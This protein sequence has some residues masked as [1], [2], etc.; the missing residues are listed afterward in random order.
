MLES[1]GEIWREQWKAEGLLAGLAKGRAEGLEKGRAEGLEEG[2]AEGLEEGRARALLRLLERRFG[3][4]PEDQR[5]RV[6]TAGSDTLD[7]WLD[8]V[9][10]A[11]TPD[12]VFERR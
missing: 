8:R 2:R 7:L 1:L 5:A 12:A 4:L 10:D 3:P 9:L 11:P 6:L